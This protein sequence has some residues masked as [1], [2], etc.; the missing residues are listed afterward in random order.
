MTYAEANTAVL[1]AFKKANRRQMTFTHQRRAL[2]DALT[3]HGYKSIAAIPADKLDVVV[4][5]LCAAI[6]GAKK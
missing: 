3:F 4:A 2:A 1:A 6:Q 5:D